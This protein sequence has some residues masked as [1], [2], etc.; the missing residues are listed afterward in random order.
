MD[1]LAHALWTN[2]AFYKKYKQQKTQRF[3]AVIFGLLPDFV[4]F[5]PVF[6]YFIFSGISFSQDLYENLSAAPWPVR[7]SFESY[8]YTHSLVIFAG[9]FLMVMLLRKGR[10]YWPLLGWALHIIIDLFTHTE[11]FFPTPV[12]FPLSGA[13]NPIAVSW[14]TPWF[15]LINY[16]CLAVVY[17]VIFWWGRKRKSEER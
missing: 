2:A 15:M 4:S 8:N 12:F 3:L 7:Y 9:V 16:S 13:H 5:A 17:G 6:I 10:P 14:G 11:K 1:V